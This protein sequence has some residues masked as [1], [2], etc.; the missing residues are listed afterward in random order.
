MARKNKF[1]QGP[2]LR[3]PLVVFSFILAGRYLYWNDKPQHPSWLGS[4][5]I[6]TIA[7]SARRGIIREAIERK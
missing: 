2:V 5:Q 6:N 7:H 4:M 1:E 3:D